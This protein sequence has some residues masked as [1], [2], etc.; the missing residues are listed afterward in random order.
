MTFP[1]LTHYSHEHVSKVLPAEPQA[2]YP[3]PKPHG[4]WVSVDEGERGWAEWCRSE[5]YRLGA[6][7]H[8]HDV[9]LR[10]DA[11]VLVLSSA[12]DLDE[13]TAG[14]AVQTQDF[15]AS[16]YILWHRVAALYSGIIIAPYIWARRLDGRASGW[17]YGWDC[18]SGCIWDASVV[19]S[20]TLRQ[21]AEVAA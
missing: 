8:V 16:T 20:I 2:S 18:A 1:A 4:F 19:E 6:L 5:E 9:K 21:R 11:N 14:F 17:Y 13:F 10:R 12:Y 15:F 3:A 7:S